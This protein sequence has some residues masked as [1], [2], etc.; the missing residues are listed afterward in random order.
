[1]TKR[2]YLLL[3]AALVAVSL[4]WP[5]LAE[6]RGGHGGGH[7]GF[8]GGGRGFHG[9]GHFGGFYRGYHGG[10]YGHYYGNTYGYSRYDS[11]DRISYRKCWRDEDGDRHCRQAVRYAC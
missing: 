10:Y 2:R 3:A 1:M 11:C 4:P 5:D 7:G 6:A 8:S 9:R